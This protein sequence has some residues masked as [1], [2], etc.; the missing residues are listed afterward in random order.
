MLFF[1]VHDT[2]V[3]LIENLLFYALEFFFRLKTDLQGKE[4]NA[5]ISSDMETRGAKRDWKNFQLQKFNCWVSTKLF[6][7]F[8]AKRLSMIQ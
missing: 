6:G 3:L 1:S 4:K 5:I 7:S 2:H 8:K